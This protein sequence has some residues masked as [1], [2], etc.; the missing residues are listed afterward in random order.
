MSRRIF[1]FIAAMAVLGSVAGAPAEVVFLRDVRPI[2]SSHCFKCHGPDETTRKANLRLD[3]RE[4]GLKPAK[5]GAAAIVP[6]DAEKSELVKRILASDEDDLMPPPAAK[7]PLS[8][9]QKE[10]LRRWIAEGAEYRPHWAFEKPK[11]AEL[12]KVAEKSWPRNEID[13]FVLA[14]LEKEGLKPS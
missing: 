8:A 12:P 10:T 3:V 1:H 2:L 5:S 11:Q 14:R 13:Y 7:I 9:A 4:E 6:G